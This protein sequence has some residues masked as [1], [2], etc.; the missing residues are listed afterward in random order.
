MKET[1]R[2]IVKSLVFWLLWEGESSTLFYKEIN[3]INIPDK[4]EPYFRQNGKF[5][6]K[7]V[8]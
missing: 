4:D 2:E 1:R 3:S 7:K 6:G 8:C 5:I